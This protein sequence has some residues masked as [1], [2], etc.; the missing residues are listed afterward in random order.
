MPIPTAPF[1]PSL[2]RRLWVGAGA[3][4]HLMKD[5]TDPYYGPLFQESLDGTKYARLAE[6]LLAEP[7][8]SRLLTE[9]PSLASGAV[10]FAALLAL[11]PG[12]L[13]HQYV[14]FYDQPGV[15]PLQS[16]ERTLSN[17]QYIAQRMRETHDLHHLLTGF[18]TDTISEHELQAYQYG[19]LGTPTS[20][21]ALLGSF[22]R[23]YPVPRSDYLRR[24]RRAYRRG[25][26]SP[27]L[28]GIHWEDHWEQSLASIRERFCA[29][30]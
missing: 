13:G 5:V 2:I 30:P 25:R 3:F 28:A 7:E 8:G 15:R 12:T 11:P 20:L 19:N 22:H 10:D 24:L 4:R 27:P 26:A 21:L 1:E 29:A 23:R 6:R 16:R 9:R 18:G 17:G 14:R